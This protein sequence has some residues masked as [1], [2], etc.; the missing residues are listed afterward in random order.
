MATLLW[1]VERPSILDRPLGPRPA[2]LS[3]RLAAEAAAMMAPQGLAGGG[4]TK[5]AG[6]RRGGEATL[7]ELLVGAWEGLSAHRSVA[8]PVC[9]GPMTPRSGASGGAC[10]DCGAHLR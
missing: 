6:R 2:P 4:H 1:D 3:E 5:L 8:C 7:D 10:G 9:A